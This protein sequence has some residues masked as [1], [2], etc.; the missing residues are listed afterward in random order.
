MALRW[1]CLFLFFKL[2]N[3]A[4]VQFWISNRAISFSFFFPFMIR[5]QLFPFHLFNQHEY[6]KWKIIII[7]YWIIDLHIIITLYILLLLIQKQKWH[8]YHN[9][10]MKKKKKKKNSVTFLLLLL[11][12]LLLSPNGYYG[13]N[14]DNH[15]RIQEFD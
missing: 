9:L 12:S 13:S 15:T 3:L 10:S 2:K 1:S 5:R 8:Y 11:L 6:Y 7:C 14:I 4:V